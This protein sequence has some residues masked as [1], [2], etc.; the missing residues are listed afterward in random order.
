MDKFDQSFFQLPLELGKHTHFSMLQY[1]K[2][3]PIWSEKIMKFPFKLVCD[4]DT[5]WK[6]FLFTIIKRL[7]LYG[8][9]FTP[10]SLTMSRLVETKSARLQ[11]DTQNTCST[12]TRRTKPPQGSLHWSC[13]NFS[14]FVG[15]SVLGSKSLA[16]KLLVAGRRFV[17]ISLSAHP[18]LNLLSGWSVL[19][20]AVSGFWRKHN[21]RSTSEADTSSF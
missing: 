16:C 7:I 13:S 14:K 4:T 21:A 12:I 3:K 10:V 6:I 8:Y 9:L 2:D 5:D 1:M 15:K 18:A 17:W 11:L 20:I 19:S